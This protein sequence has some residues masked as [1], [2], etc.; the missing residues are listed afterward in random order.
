VRS[1]F[2]S[3]V[4]IVHLADAFLPQVFPTRFRNSAQGSSAAAGN[5][6][7]TIPALSFN[8]LS[9]KVGTPVILWTPRFVLDLRKWDLFLM[10]NYRSFSHVVF[11]AH[12]GRTL[13]GYNLTLD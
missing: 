7:A 3:Q 9:K 10:I 13:F 11:Q 12:V 5:A 1:S 8:S 6:S 4:V 2:I